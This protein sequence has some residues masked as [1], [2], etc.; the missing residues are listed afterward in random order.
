MTKASQITNLASRKNTKSTLLDESFSNLFGNG[1][2]NDKVEIH[3]LSLD[4]L[5]DFKGHVFNMYSQAKLKQMANSIKRRGIDTPILVRAIEN[6]HYE[7]IAGHNRTAASRL[8]G[9]DTIPAIVLDVDDDTAALIMTESNLIQRSKITRCELGRALVKQMEVLNRQGQRTDL[10]LSQ[11]D[12]KFDALS[13][14]AE[15]HDMKRAQIHRFMRLG[16]LIPEL[17]EPVDHNKIGFVIGV[18]LS[19]LSP[20][21]QNAVSS[22]HGKNGFILSAT[23]AG[24]MKTHE[25]DGTL[26]DEKIRELMI[27]N[28]SPP[29]DIKIP[30]KKLEQFNIPNDKLF[31]VIL[32]ALEMYMKTK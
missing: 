20:E 22:L 16:R 17:A 18:E 7:I 14:L 13:I 6:G 24:A 21:Y 31:D 8:A 9:C 28:S 5:T 11:N 30:Y 2:K 27:G 10:S 23:N 25:K 15:R 3:Q 12:T 19:Y 4:K 1:L 26:T 32:E 29:K